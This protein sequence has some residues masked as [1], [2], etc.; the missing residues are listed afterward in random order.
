MTTTR[1]L[2]SQSCVI[3]ELPP[4]SSLKRLRST[5]CANSP[6]TE[7]PVRDLRCSYLD[8]FDWRLY[9]A[10]MVLASAWQEDCL[11][12]RL[13]S[14]GEPWC[15]TT[16][17]QASCPKLAN[18][19][20]DPRLRALVAPAVNGRALLPL[21]SVDCRERLFRILNKDGKTVVKLQFCEERL[22]SR[23]HR[24]TPD[25][26]SWLCLSAIRGYESALEKWR[27]LVC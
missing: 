9:D 3:F 4:D 6:I 8:S 17:A 13:C 27:A 20:A 26:G 1:P 2:G 25:L 24:G 11:R 16:P 15:Y 14:L 5:L 12:L 22:G 18:D 23:E 19:I 21:V 7:E 10:G